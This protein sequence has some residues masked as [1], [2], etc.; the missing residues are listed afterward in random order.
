MFLTIGSSHQSS[1]TPQSTYT[2]LAIGS[3]HQSSLTSLSSYTFLA[4]GSSHQSSL[5]SQSTYTFRV[6][7]SCH[8]SSKQIFCDFKPLLELTDSLINS[9]TSKSPT[10][11]QTSQSWEVLLEFID[12]PIHS[13]T[14][15]NWELLSKLFDSQ[16]N[17][18]TSC[19]WEPLLEY[20]YSPID[21]QSLYNWELLSELIDPPMDIQIFCNCKLFSE[22][23]DSPINTQTSHNWKLYQ[24]LLT[25][26][27]THTVVMMTCWLGDC[28]YMSLEQCKVVWVNSICH[29][30]FPAIFYYITIFF[31]SS[32]CYDNGFTSFFPTSNNCQ[33]YLILPKFILFSWVVLEILLKCNSTQKYWYLIEHFTPLSLFLSS[34]PPK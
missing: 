29:L 6:I 27:L 13:Q 34:P 14:Y 10:D 19:S 15:Y 25:P 20:A 32:H 3:S 12:T 23:I 33:S 5:T 28:W 21:A 8:Q 18:H 1:L 7:G 24:S 4:I 11:S 17:T 22:L 16:I 31:L 9:Q 26:W 2:F 30:S